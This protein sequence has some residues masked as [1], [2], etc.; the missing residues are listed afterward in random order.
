LK[1]RGSDRTDTSSSPPRGTAPV[2]TAVAADWDEEFE[3]HPD[4]PNAQ[5]AA[6]ATET[7]SRRLSPVKI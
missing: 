3:R 4:A 2:E 1:L 5:R 6:Q 7:V